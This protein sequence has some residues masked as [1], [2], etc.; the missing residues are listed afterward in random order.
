[1]TDH[2]EF[3]VV[4]VINLNLFQLSP[5]PAGAPTPNIPDVPAGSERIGLFGCK[6]TPISNGDIDSQSEEWWSGFFINGGGS[7][8]ISWGEEDIGK[9]IRALDDEVRPYVFIVVP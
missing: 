7:G 3:L 5:S 8:A 9:Q 6:P 1:M 2:V 4:E